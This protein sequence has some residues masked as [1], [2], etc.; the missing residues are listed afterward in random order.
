MIVINNIF[1]SIKWVIKDGQRYKVS[2]IIVMRL[3]EA[4]LWKMKVQSKFSYI[5]Y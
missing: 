1:L 2:L 5:L 4:Y 3:L